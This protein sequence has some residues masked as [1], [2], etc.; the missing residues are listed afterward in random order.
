MA[1]SCF[2]CGKKKRGGSTFYKLDQ[3]GHEIC[4][5]CISKGYF[6]TALELIE[7][8]KQADIINAERRRNNETDKI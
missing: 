1:K 3:E 5:S 6:K 8:N 2:Y 4:L 7:H